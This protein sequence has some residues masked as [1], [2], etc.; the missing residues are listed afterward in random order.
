MEY[1]S[2]LFKLQL[3]TKKENIE[4]IREELIKSRLVIKF[5]SGLAGLWMEI[6][7]L[8]D[9]KIWESFYFYLSSYDEYTIRNFWNIFPSR[10]IIL[11]KLHSY[12][13]INEKKNTGSNGLRAFSFIEANFSTTLFFPYEKTQRSK[14]KV[15][16]IRVTLKSIS[17]HT[18]NFHVSYCFPKL[19][20]SGK[21]LVAGMI[22]ES[23]R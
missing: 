5:L 3:L 15:N 4:K 22:D 2:Q 17:D 16:L 13:E 7:K 8:K 14:N 10:Q 19:T 1:S 9:K 18:S 12:F 21:Y 11:N 20:V 23:V 6:R